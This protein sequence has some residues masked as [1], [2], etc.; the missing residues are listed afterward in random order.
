MCTDPF[1]LALWICALTA[2]GAPVDFD[3]AGELD[4]LADLCLAA[5]PPVARA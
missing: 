3:P 2:P 4:E 1:V 5:W